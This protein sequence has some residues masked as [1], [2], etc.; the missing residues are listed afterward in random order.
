MPSIPS[1]VYLL[2]SILHSH[3]VVHLS[4]IIFFYLFIKLSAIQLVFGSI[5]TISIYITHF[6]LFDKSS[7]AFYINYN[8]YYILYINLFIY[9]ISFELSYHLTAHLSLI[10]LS[11]CIY[12]FIFIYIYL[13]ISIYFYLS[14]PFYL[15][16]SIFIFLY[17]YFSLLLII[18]FL[19][20][21]IKQNIKLKSLQNP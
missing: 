14:V 18:F 8:I 21:I 3:T 4:Y 9:S 12:I 19:H 5:D 1:S 7:Y 13:T 20:I 16:L 11:T 15:Y 10:Y 6:Y 2:N 17:L